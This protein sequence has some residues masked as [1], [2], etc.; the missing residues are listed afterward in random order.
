MR[1]F[2]IR[3]DGEEY[4][5]EVE[6]MEGETNKRKPSTK[7]PSTTEKQNYPVTKKSKKQ[8]TVQSKNNQNANELTA[9]MPGK[10][11]DIKV[12]EG[13]E[14]N[15]GDVLIVLEA[16]KLENNISAPFSAKIREIKTEVG[17]NVE[18][19]E[20]LIELE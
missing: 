1:K 12:K 7:S 16:M 19:G 15:K 13:Q 8:K 3:I 11:L 17:K 2:K 14:V 4:I 6:E 18:A 5:V 9:P 10:I 20:V